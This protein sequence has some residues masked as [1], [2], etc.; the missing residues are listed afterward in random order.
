[1]CR[2]FKNSTREVLE[3]HELQAIASRTSRVFLKNPKYLIYNSTMYE[4]QGFYFFYKT[5]HALRMIILL[6]WAVCIISQ[7]C[8][9]LTKRACFMEI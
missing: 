2:V 4:E 1:M 6:T 7:Q 3:K 8:T 9:H 5:Y